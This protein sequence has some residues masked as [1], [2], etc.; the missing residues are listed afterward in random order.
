MLP[1]QHGRQVLEAR[2]WPGIVN[3]DSGVETQTGEMATGREPGG[4]TDAKRC[5]GA[6]LPRGGLLPGNDCAAASTT[7]GTSRKPV[8][9]MIDHYNKKMYN[10]CMVLTL[11]NTEG[12]DYF[13]Q[14]AD[15]D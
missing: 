1:A 9:R 12:G 7:S 5:T 3:T 4:A 13:E 8:N 10:A 2:R 11:F 14:T 15:S 6:G